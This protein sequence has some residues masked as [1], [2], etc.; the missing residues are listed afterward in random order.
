MF[1]AQQEGK[2]ISWLMCIPQSTAVNADVDASPFEPFSV[3]SILSQT[4]Q[5]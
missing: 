2:F 3:D 5:S 4:K 1:V